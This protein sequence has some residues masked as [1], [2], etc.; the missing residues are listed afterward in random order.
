MGAVD[1]EIRPV[2]GEATGPGEQLFL[3]WADVYGA[4]GRHA[5]GPAHSSWSA[6][7]RRELLRSTERQRLAWAAVAGD[8]VLGAVTLAMPLHDNLEVADLDLAVHTDRRRQGVGSLLLATAESAATQAGRSTLVA[9][10]Q[11]AIGQDD[12]GGAFAARHGYA[13]AQTVLRNT[14]SLPADRERL[15]EVVAADGAAG[16]RLQTCWDGVPQEW[17]E[18]RAELSRRMSTD[19]PL[20]DLRL[21]EEVWDADRVRSTYTQ[22]AAMGRRVV[23][24]FAVHEATGRLVGYTQVQVDH[25]GVAHQ[26]DTLVVRDHRGHGLGLRLKAASTLAVMD[27]LPSVAGIRTWNAEDNL[28]MLG[29]NRALGYEQDAWMREWQKVV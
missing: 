5:F 18:G 21:E 12:E 13:A 6:Q 19:V 1:V 28:P 15:Q 27:E 23:D 2:S 10:T 20:G 8:T 26:Q 17:L 22:I 25:G 3:A 4:S 29:V 11:W 16:Y 14:L 24:T 7:E 9:E